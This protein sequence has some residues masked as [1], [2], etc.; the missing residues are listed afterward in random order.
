MEGFKCIMPSLW[1]K[2]LA[3]MF[4]DRVN[5]ETHDTLCGFDDRQDYYYRTEGA[6]IVLLTEAKRVKAYSVESSLLEL[7]RE[8]D[9]YFM[10]DSGEGD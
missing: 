1:S 8:L 4:I 9:K 5:E 7:R 2:W 3:G 10:L 6:W